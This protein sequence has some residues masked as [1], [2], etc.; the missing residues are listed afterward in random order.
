M[1]NCKILVLVP[2]LSFEIHLSVLEQ[3]C[4]VMEYYREITTSLARW[5]MDLVVLWADFVGA[6]STLNPGAPTGLTS[7]YDICNHIQSLRDEW[8]NEADLR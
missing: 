7:G 5:I 1:A 2:I 6:P 4:T 3:G 8:C